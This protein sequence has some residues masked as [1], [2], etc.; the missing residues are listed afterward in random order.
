MKFCLQRN[1]SF[2]PVPRCAPR[3]G[4]KTRA[5][6]L[7]AALSLFAI[8]FPISAAPATQPYLL[9][10]PGIGGH[11]PLDDHLILGLRE[12]GIGGWLE[13]YDWTG[14]DR[15]LIALMQEKR[16]DEQ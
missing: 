7:L 15:G 10:L 4:L 16:H 2:Q 6:S 5:T 13:I 1:M 12:A 8:V 3:H 11:L 9:H 14:T